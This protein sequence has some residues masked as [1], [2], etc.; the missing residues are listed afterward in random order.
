MSIRFDNGTIRKAEITPEGYLRA[1]AVFA[2]DGVLEYRTLDGKTR[3]EL[4]LPE[5]NK[6][7]LTGFGLKP[8]TIEHPT[9]LVD[10]KNAN[11]HAKGLTDSN[12]VYDKGGF[13]R[14]V[15]NVFDS[16]AVDSITS[17]KTVEIS[18]G[19]QCDV[20]DSPGVWNGQ[21][22][23]AIQRNLV[24]NHVC[25]TQK[26][27]AGEEVRIMHLDS[28]EDIAYEIG[29]IGDFVKED[30]LPIPSPQSPTKN[31]KMAK[32]TLDGVEY[33]DIP[34]SFASVFSQKMVELNKANSRNDSLT[35]QVGEISTLREQ[36]KEA[37]ANH[38]RQ[39]GR[40][41]GYEEIVSAAIPVLEEAGYYWDSD[42][43]NFVLDAKK[44]AFL[45]E[46]EDMEEDEDEDEEDMEEE[47]PPK[48]GKTKKD[49]YYADSIADL[50][51]AWKEADAIVPG[52][53]E[54]KFDSNLDCADVRRLVVESVT[55]KDFADKSDDYITSRFDSI[56]ENLSERKDSGRNSSYIE[57]LTTVVSTRNDAKKGC[58]CEMSESEK[59]RADNY[60]KPIGMSRGK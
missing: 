36:L 25:A 20:E 13:V 57:E 18:A 19:Y 1:E 39:M 11:Q 31:K 48:K 15:I 60:K 21:H 47:V 9:V 22:Y 33:S 7:A 51:T 56:K 55:K 16:V 54:N 14:G 42:D 30:A 32:V 24:I 45:E 49:S 50:L 35:E 38:D 28:A 4:R 8:F 3:R 59:R 17:G 6:K 43:R 37:N 53:S 2:R 41:D 58:N 5:E 40:A 23:D 26:G 10:A 29:S 12:V 52:I 34:E 46:E 27:R 44:P